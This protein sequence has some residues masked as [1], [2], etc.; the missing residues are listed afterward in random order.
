[1]QPSQVTCSGDGS[2]SD[3][4]EEDTSDEYFRSSEDNEAHDES[5]TDEFAPF[6]QNTVHS[7]EDS[8]DET[9]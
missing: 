2:E 1:M 4:P 5:L 3:D 8:G 6:S 9:D 7:D